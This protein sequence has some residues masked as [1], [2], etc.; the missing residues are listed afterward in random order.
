MLILTSILYF[1]L[2]IL[3]VFVTTDIDNSECLPPP[4][5]SNPAPSGAKRLLLHIPGAE[6]QEQAKAGRSNITLPEQPTVFNP[7]EQIEELNVGYYSSG[8]STEGQKLYHKPS[9]GTS[10]EV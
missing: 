5:S 7:I 6:M 4:V 9:T 1:K 8:G 3:D 10:V 2:L